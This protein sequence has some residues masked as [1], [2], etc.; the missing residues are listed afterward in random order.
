VA[1]GYAQGTNADKITMLENDIEELAKRL[2]KDVELFGEWE[3]SA[4]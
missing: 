1:T 3:S 4:R 2:A